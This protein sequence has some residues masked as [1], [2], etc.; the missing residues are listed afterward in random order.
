MNS[1]CRDRKGRVRYY[2]DHIARLLR[3]RDMISRDSVIE[4][5]PYEID[6]VRAQYEQGWR[7]APDPARSLDDKVKLAPLLVLGHRVA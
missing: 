4:V 5:P 1:D 6:G 2:W 7:L 3:V